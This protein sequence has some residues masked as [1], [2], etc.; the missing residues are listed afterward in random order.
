MMD[1]TKIESG[2]V[3]FWLFKDNKFYYLRD[4]RT[5]RLL[6]RSTSFDYVWDVLRKEIGPQQSKA[7]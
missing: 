6:A 3:S 5:D 4:A 7:E 2:K 1:S